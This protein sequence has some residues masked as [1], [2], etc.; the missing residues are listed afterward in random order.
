MNARKQIGKNLGDIIQYS[1]LTM[2]E[3]AHALGVNPGAVFGM[4]KGKWYPRVPHLL[5]LCKILDCT[6]EEILGTPTMMVEEGDEN[7]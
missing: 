6:Y 2:T 4:V 1:G 5:K 3:V 7:S